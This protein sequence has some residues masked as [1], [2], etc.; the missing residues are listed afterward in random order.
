MAHLLLYALAGAFIYCAVP[1]EWGSPARLLRQVLL[2]I[3]VL[4]LIRLSRA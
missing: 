4:M 3:G 1:G 2:A